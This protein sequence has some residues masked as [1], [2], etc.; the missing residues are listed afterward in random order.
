MK[1]KIILSNRERT[2][3]FLYFEKFEGIK[4]KINLQ[5]LKDAISNLEAF[6]EKGLAPEK[7]VLG[8]S[9]EEVGLPGTVV[10]FLDGKEK[11][12]M[13]IAPIISEEEEEEE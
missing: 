13:A 9:T 1:G 5:Y 4:T 11:C 2:V 6:Q 10:F 12:G 8:I 7:I 3:G